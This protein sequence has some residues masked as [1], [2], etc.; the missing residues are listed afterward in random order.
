MEEVDIG[1]LREMVHVKEED[2]R[3]LDELVVKQEHGK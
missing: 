3:K 1:K 2:T